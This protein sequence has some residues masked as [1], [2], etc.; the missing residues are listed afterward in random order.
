MFILLVLII[1]LKVFSFAFDYDNYVSDVHQVVEI[2][3]DLDEMCCHCWNN[4][5]EMECRCHGNKLLKVPEN[6]PEE[7]GA[8]SI[9]DAGVKILEKDSFLRHRNNLKDM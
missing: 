9:S 6:L 4:S 5:K 1:N 2:N 8:F 3:C 7:M